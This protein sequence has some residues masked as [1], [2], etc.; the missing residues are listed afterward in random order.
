MRGPTWRARPGPALASGG[1]FGP[2]VRTSCGA[3]SAAVDSI[4]QIHSA[5]A[6]VLV[7]AVL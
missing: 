5:S 6:P 7:R 2:K 3:A 4:D 1:Y